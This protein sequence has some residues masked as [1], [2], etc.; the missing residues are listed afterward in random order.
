CSSSHL[1][2]PADMM[3]APGGLIKRSGVGIF[4]QAMEEGKVQL[5]HFI[6][7]ALGEAAVNAT[8]E[9][10]QGLATGRT[11]LMCAAKLPRTADRTQFL[12]L[13]LA[14]GA[15]VDRRDSEGRTALSLASECGHLDAVRL[16]VQNGAHPGSS[17]SQGRTPLAYA[18]TP[19]A[20][21]ATPLPHIPGVEV[22]D[23]DLEEL[24]PEDYTETESLRLMTG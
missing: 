4:L 16:L 23:T 13:L 19:S 6:L 3:D 1:G 22:S 20:G 8:I 14:R 15:E 18:Q 7:A 2:T 5:A 21:Q 9:E 24:V 17:D 11:P 10:Q 12:R